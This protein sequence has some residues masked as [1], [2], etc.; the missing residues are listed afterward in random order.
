M[1]AITRKAVMAAVVIGAGLAPVGLA[2]AG[3]ASTGGDRMAVDAHRDR[4]LELVGNRTSMKGPEMPAVGDSLV[5]TIDFNDKK[6][7]SPFGKVSVTC[8]IVEMPSDKGPEALCHGTLSTDKG[9]LYLGGL[10]PMYGPFPRSH[11]IAV[12]GG[13]GDYASARGSAEVV[14]PD[15]MSSRLT[16]RLAS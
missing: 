2:G 6:T 8:T 4:V 5:S 7:G 9:S 11:T 12:L 3:W 1:I 14:N 10:N 15:M 13:T 16:I